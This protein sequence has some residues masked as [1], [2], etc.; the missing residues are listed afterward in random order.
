VAKMSNYL[1]YG[2][3]VAIGLGAG[4]AYLKVQEA[5]R[6]GE[7]EACKKIRFTET[8]SLAGGL[9]G[10]AAGG[11]VGSIVAAAVCSFGVYGKAVCGIATVGGG[12]FLGSKAGEKFGESMM[13]WTYDVFH[14]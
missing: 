2:G 1:K 7:T 8:G 13:E 12:S 9:A 4:S 11:K 3:Y 14:D 6:A 10:S 5:C